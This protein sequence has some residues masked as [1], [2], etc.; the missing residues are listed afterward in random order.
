MV[1]T[2]ARGTQAA[3]G[4]IMSAVY[5]EDQIQLAR[6]QMALKAE[7][8]RFQQTQALYQEQE[9]MQATRNQ[10]YVDMIDAAGRAIRGY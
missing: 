8:Q 10:G 4:T 5:T 1:D 6:M 2:A 7:Q 3:V 9:R